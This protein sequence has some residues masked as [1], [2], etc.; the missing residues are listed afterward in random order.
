MQI[1]RSFLATVALAV[2]TAALSQTA[3]QPPREY[4]VT[5]LV[6]NVSGGAPV[7]DPGLVN[8]W[9]L[10][11]SSTGDWWVSDNT[12]GLSTLYDGTGKITPLVVTIPTGDSSAS[13]TGSPTGTVFNGT[14]DFAVAPGKPADFL[15]AT[16]DGTI[17]GWNPGAAPTAAIIEVN[18][19]QA[20]VFK[21]LTIAQARVGGVLGNYLYVADFR[22]ARVAVYTGSF[23]H[24]T[25]LEQAIAKTPIP[26]GYAPFNV[27]NLG[28]NIYVTL[29]KQDAAKHDQVRGAGQGL[30]AVITPE[31]KL[32]QI[33]EAGPW[34]NAPWGVAIASG[35]FG[36]FSHDVLVG[37]FGDGTV[38]AFNPVT[39]PPPPPRRVQG[40]AGRCERQCDRD[41]GAL[42]AFFRQRH[43]A[44]RPGD[45]AVLRGGSG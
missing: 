21:G 4:A 7:T 30:V 36:A 9:G 3:P 45:D 39:P 6:T 13:S 44:R 17:S 12:S 33:F 31:G 10:S 20:S 41:S 27:Q 29:A 40:Q 19:K 2:S 16:E 8:P 37:N 15:F 32:I 35:D 24:A 43:Y 1:R 23:A 42:G 28:G 25:E 34:F 22:Q 38:M 18:E 11:R 5:P 14:T 26:A